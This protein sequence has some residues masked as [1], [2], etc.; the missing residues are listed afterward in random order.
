MV[1]PSGS[2]DG[3]GEATRVQGIDSAWNTRSDTS[4]TDVARSEARV[5]VQAPITTHHTSLRCGCSSWNKD[6]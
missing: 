4:R 6:D 3:F 2:A 1:V 5:V